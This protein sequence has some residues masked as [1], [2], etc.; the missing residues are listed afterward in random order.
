MLGI[1]DPWVATTYLLCIASAL[2][3]LGW[4]IRKWNEDDLEAE[5]EEE[6]RQWAEEEDRVE[7]EL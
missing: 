1:A 7:Q 4:G 2:F 3:C 6:I 5:S